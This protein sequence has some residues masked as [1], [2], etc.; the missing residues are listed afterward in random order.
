ML[1]AVAVPL[2]EVALVQVEQ[3]VVELLQT[4]A[5]LE[6]QIKAAVAALVLLAM[7]AVAARAMSLSF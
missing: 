4:Q 5:T 7:A 6:L 1:E 3:V 2:R